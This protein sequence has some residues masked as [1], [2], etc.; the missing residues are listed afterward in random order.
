MLTQLSGHI[1]KQSKGYCG[2]LQ[3]KVK[4]NFIPTLHSSG[5]VCHKFPLVSTYM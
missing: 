4:N 1:T 5:Q 2:L 3:M